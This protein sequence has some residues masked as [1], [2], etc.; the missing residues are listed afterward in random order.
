MA[1]ARIPAYDPT[2][3]HDLD[4]FAAGISGTVIRPEDEGYDLAR[5][6]HNAHDRPPPALIVEAAIAADVSRTVVFA[7]DA[8][9]ELAVRGGSH[10]LAGYGTSEGGVVLDLAP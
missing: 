4:T 1:L 3:P 8:G 6:V 9:L 5:Q 10:S 2:S 7:R